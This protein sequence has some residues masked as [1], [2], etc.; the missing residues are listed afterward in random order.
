MARVNDVGGVTGFGAVDTGESS[1][2]FRAD[3]EARVHAMQAALRGRG[4]WTADEFR[5]AVERLPPAV[6]LASSTYQRWFAAT[7]MLL[8]EKGLV[9]NEDLP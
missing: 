6:Y 4:L 7:C 9:A 3:W 2:P 5:D 8:V 1:E